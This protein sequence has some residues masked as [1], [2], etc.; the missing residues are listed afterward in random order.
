MTLK[1]FW[2]QCSGIVYVPVHYLLLQTT[3][4]KHTY[5]FCLYFSAETHQ[6]LMNQRRQT[7]AAKL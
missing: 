4:V 5:I 6:S 3:F 2:C 7:K 1:L